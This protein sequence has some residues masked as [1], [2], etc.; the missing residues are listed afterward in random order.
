MCLLFHGC[1]LC[2]R[3]I[4][5]ESQMSPRWAGCR[6]DCC[7]RLHIWCSMISLA[8][9]IGSVLNGLL[10]WVFIVCI[11]VEAMK[12]KDARTDR[13]L[14]GLVLKWGYF[15]PSPATKLI[16]LIH[17]KLAYGSESRFPLCLSDKKNAHSIFHLTNYLY[18]KTCTTLWDLNSFFRNRTKA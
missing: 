17:R 2:L 9:D 10:N 5:L 3:H 13:R 4:V 1:L 15:D 8:H 14:L 18:P 12:A 16:Q 7:Q 6:L 11:S